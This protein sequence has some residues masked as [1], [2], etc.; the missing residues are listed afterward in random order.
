MVLAGDGVQRY[1]STY[2]PTF[3][4]FCGWIREADLCNVIEGSS[5]VLCVL[6]PFC[7]PNL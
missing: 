5:A 3:S 1:L 4:F 7:K 2:L 6:T